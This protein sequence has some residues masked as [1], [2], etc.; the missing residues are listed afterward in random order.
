MYPPPSSSPDLNC[1]NCDNPLYVSIPWQA[2][3]ALAGLSPSQPK[4]PKSLFIEVIETLPK[5]VIVSLLV[6]HTIQFL[7]RTYDRI[8]ARV[9]EMGWF[10]SSSSS[11]HRPSY[12]RSSSG[13]TY[14]RSS[15]YRGHRVRPRDGYIKYLIYKLKVLFHDLVKYGKRHPFKV[16]FLVIMPL[17]SG[18]VLASIAKTFGIK[19][20]AFLMGA[21]AAKEMAGGSG[22]YYGS[23][24]YDDGFDIGGIAKGAG[25][26]GGLMNGDTLGSALKIA[27]AFM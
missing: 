5:A 6:R 22:G 9:K 23:K 24:G 26:G 4:E 8:I 1:P 18:G 14:S 12:A 21:K 16:F 3:S 15:S 10:S 19:L 7:E 13:S 2:L 20:P 17:I 27:K 25:L 11:H